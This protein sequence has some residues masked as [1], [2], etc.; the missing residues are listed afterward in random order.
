MEGWTVGDS[1]PVHFKAFFL[2]ADSYVDLMLSFRMAFMEVGWVGLAM[3]CMPYFPAF[4]LL[5]YIGHN[6]RCE[7]NTRRY[8]IL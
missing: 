6:E 8:N 2:P 1:Y 7:G 3:A 5:L 4:V